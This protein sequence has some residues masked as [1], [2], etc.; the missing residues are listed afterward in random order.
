MKEN[1]KYNVQQLLNFEGTAETKWGLFKIIT[2]ESGEEQE[3][4]LKAF[5]SEDEAIDI[6]TDLINN[7]YP[8]EDNIFDPTEQ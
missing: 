2:S 6:Y 7:F 5:D 3:M 1:K 8:N 4:L